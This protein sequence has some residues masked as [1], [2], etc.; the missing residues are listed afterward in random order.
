MPHMTAGRES[1][2]DI[3]ARRGGSAIRVL[4]VDDAAL[5]RHGFALTLEAGGEIQVVGEAADGAAAVREVARLAP[6][7]VLMDVQMPGLDGLEATR[8]ITAANPSVRSAGRRST[9]FRR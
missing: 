4:L 7:V 8:H 6:D 9:R 5:V 2:A 1:S 3:P